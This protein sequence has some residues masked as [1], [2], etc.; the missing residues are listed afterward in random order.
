MITRCNTRPTSVPGATIRAI[1]SDPGRLP[2][3][4]STAAPGAH[5]PRLRR[6][7]WRPGPGPGPDDAGGAWVSLRL[8]RGGLSCLDP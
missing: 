8:I 7:M 2:V 4:V 5:L 3:P 1:A 6:G